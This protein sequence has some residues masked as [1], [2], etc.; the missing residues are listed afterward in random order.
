M[1]E[2]WRLVLILKI[3]LVMVLIVGAF[4]TCVPTAS[5]EDTNLSSGTTTLIREIDE[6]AGVVC[7][8]YIGYYKGG[9]DCMP[10]ADT[11]LD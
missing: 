5:N 8:V 4:A 1:K 11:L 2:N 3:T 6:E 9:V 10:I 7:W